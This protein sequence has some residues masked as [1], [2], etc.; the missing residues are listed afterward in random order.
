VCG[1][2][3]GE[4]WRRLAGLVWNVLSRSFDISA[5]LH[6]STLY[7][8]SLTSLHTH[9]V[10]RRRLLPPPTR[11]T[12]LWRRHPAKTRAFRA[13]LRARA[14]HHHQLYIDHRTTNTRRRHEHRKQIPLHRPPQRRATRDNSPIRTRTGTGT[15]TNPLRFRPAVLYLPS[16]QPPHPAEQAP[17][18]STTR[19]RRRRRRRSF[20]RPRPST[21]SLSRAPALPR[22]L[23]S[24]VASRP[25]QTRA[26]LSVRVRVGS[27]PAGW[28]WC[29]GAG[30][31]P[32]AGEG[33]DEGGYG[34]V[35]G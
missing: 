21:R 14:Q 5:T 6:S 33:A 16:L 32:G 34:W 30:G 26:A 31:D 35:G 28:T 12:S 9:H 11:P 22:A 15:S 19:R 1:G 4:R 24:A 17:S 13:V 27:R 25:E 23:A 3:G 29:A 20:K 2:G 10:R 8:H 7:T 18:L